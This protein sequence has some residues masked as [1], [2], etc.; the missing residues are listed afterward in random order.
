MLELLE[1]CDADIVRAI[2]VFACV[3]LRLFG[4]AMRCR[5]QHA[6]RQCQQQKDTCITL[7]CAT[8]CGV[9]RKGA[10]A[11]RQIAFVMLCVFAPLWEKS[12]LCCPQKV[13][14]FYCC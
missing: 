7:H 5:G 8:L 3:C 11:R 12:F 6:Y 1:Q 14:E 10:K 9:S 2:S 13:S 4:L